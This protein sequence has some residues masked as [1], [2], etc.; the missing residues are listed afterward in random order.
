MY[1]EL[2]PVVIRNWIFLRSNHLM[3]L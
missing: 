1:I 3:S 2:Y